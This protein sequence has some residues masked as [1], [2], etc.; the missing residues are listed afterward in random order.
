MIETDASIKD[1][2]LTIKFIDSTEKTY[3]NV[4]NIDIVQPPIEREYIRQSRGYLIVYQGTERVIIP[5]DMIKD[6][7]VG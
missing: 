2:K 1:M 6:Y 4:T 3:D 5:L 7:E